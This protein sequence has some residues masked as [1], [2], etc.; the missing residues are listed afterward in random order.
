MLCFRKSEK[1]LSIMLTHRHHHEL[2]DLVSLPLL[3]GRLRENRVGPCETVCVALGLSKRLSVL[4]LKAV[5]INKVILGGQKKGMITINTFGYQ[6]F[7][8]SC[9]LSRFGHEQ[10]RRPTTKRPITD[11]PS[12]S[13][14]ACSKVKMSFTGFLLIPPTSELRHMNSKR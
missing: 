5:L 4:N 6:I 11:N 7:T 14:K 3:A 13:S 2:L 9:F 1:S 12:W 10:V 8:S